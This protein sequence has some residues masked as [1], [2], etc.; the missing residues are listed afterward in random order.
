MRGPGELQVANASPGGSICGV[1]RIEACSACPGDYEDPDRTAGPEDHA[2]AES[3][4]D[5]AVDNADFEESR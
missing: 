5:D 4:R 1:T 3:E 2:E